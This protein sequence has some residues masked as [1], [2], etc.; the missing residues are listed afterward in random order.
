MKLQIIRFKALFLMLAFSFLIYQVS[1]AGEITPDLQSKLEALGEEEKIT[2]IVEITGRIDLA[3][4]QGKTNKLKALYQFAED[5]QEELKAFLEI[6]RGA[7][8]V[9]RYR[10]F[11][12]FNGLVVA[13]TKNVITAIAARPDVKE[14]RLNRIIQIPLPTKEE[15][16][17]AEWNIEKVR[18]NEV[19]SAFGV[20]GAETIIANIDTGVNGIHPDLQANFRGG[21]YDFYDAI[22]DTFTTPYDDHWHGTHTMGTACG[23]SAS[24]TA[25][26]V[27]PGAQWIACKALNSSGSATDEWLYRAGDWVIDPDGN[28]ET[29]DIPD[30]VNNSWCDSNGSN[31]F[32]R[33]VVQTWIALDIFPAFANGNNGPGSGTVGAP[34]SYPESFGV[35]ATDINDN[36]ASF[37]SRGPSP[38]DGGI[39]PNVSAPGVNIRSSVP[40][41]YGRSQGTSMACPHVTGGVAL[42][43]SANPSLTVEQIKQILQDTAVDLGA[44]GPDNDYGWGRID[45]FEAVSRVYE[46][47]DDL[48]LQ[49]I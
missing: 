34:A 3:Q 27:A 2:V 8:K 11:K 39:K 43:K 32:Y 24:G 49:D 46:I 17:Q 21:S 5:S 15:I 25:I 14:V 22:N 48:V 7:G 4:I 9:E 42:L 45:L 47:P 30:V 29:D 37:S 13:A 28:P 16:Q 12:A 20:T 6:Q 40:G 19:W 26:G 23:N 44:A 38:I 1:S 31:Q 36:I 10:G 35:G 18:A 41:G 33:S